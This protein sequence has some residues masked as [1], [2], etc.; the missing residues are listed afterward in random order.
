MIYSYMILLKPFISAPVDIFLMLLGAFIIGFLIA[1]LLR[2]QKIVLLKKGGYQLQKDVSSLVKSND[3]LEI[4][5]MQLREELGT[6]KNN[7]EQ[8]A[9]V[10]QLDKLQNDLRSEREK[11]VT[12][13]NSLAEIERAHEALK[14]EL[15]TKLNQMI[16]NDE[17][18]RLQA[19]ANR[20]KIFNSSLQEEISMLKLQLDD[21]KKAHV[22]DIEIPK[23]VE[24]TTTA[25]VVEVDQSQETSADYAQSHPNL[26]FLDQVGI[27]RVTIDQKD[28]LK[29]I[30]GVGPFIEKKLNKLGIYSFEQIAGLSGSQIHQITEAIEFFPGR[31]ERDDWVGQARNLKG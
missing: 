10:E 24:F 6:M 15:E 8:M 26:D 30:S 31:I 7:Q 20:L 18:T 23:P 21:V 19:E 1:W 22:K 16:S 12:A 9:P 3:N 13:R 5:L 4:E 25:P 17:A 2:N 27:K 28:D 14:S 29:L 11:S